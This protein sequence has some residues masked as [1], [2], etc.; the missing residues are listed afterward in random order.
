MRIAC[1]LIPHLRARVE[2]LRQPRLQA[3]P[4]FIAGRDRGRAVVVDALPSNLGAMVGM[5]VEEALSHCTHALIVD[6]DEPAYRRVLQETLDALQGVSDRVEEGGVGVAYAGLDGLELLYGGEAGVVRALLDAVPAYLQPRAGVADGKFPALAAARTA[7]PMGAARVPGDAAAFLAPHPI[8]LLPVADAVKASMRRFGLRTL[9]DVAAW[10][11]EPLVDQFGAE[12]RLAWELAYGID[13]RPLVPRKHEETVAERLTLP[14]VS[15]SLDLLLTAVDRLLQRA[16]ARPDVRGR[17][18][19]WAR[20]ECVC[21]EGLPWEKTV[22]FKRGVG[23]WEEAAATVRRQLASDHPPRP[24]EEMGLTLGALSGGSGVQ[25]GLLPDLQ[26]DRQRQLLDVERQLQAKLRRE[27]VLH[28]IVDVAPWRPAPET[29]FLQAPVDPLA[30]DAVRPLLLPAAVAVREGPDGS[31]SAVRSDGRWRRV[32]SVDDRWAFDLW[33]QPEPVNRVYYR[34]S[35]D[36][37]VRMT[38]FRDLRSG[39]WRQQ[40]S[41]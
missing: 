17:Y 10:R 26:Q 19:G 7:H 40:R 23:A 13:R 11:V 36:D 27:S 41:A 25:L 37:D 18:A 20:V 4:V 12:G 28:R 3:A 8:G 30:G 33:W 16:F 2:L 9:G 1:V 34:V 29:R 22:H 32:V 31:P 21:A 15:A 24:V 38:L 6:A 5:T 14:L 39:C 35:R